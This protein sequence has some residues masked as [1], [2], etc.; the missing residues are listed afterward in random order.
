MIDWLIKNKYYLNILIIIII[1]TLQLYTYNN[2]I[3]TN[4]NLNNS[5]LMIAKTMVFFV[6][7]LISDPS[8]EVQIGFF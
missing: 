3:T 4:T 5:C 8:N 7:R 1:K 6:S 2:L